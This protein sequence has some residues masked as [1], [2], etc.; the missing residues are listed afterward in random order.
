MQTPAY[1]PSTYYAHCQQQRDPASRCAR[2]KR[3]TLLCKEI[4]RIWQENHHNPAGYD[5]AMPTG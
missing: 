1:A 5:A 3:D 4:T 2:A